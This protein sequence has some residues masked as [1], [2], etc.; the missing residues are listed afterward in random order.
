MKG[1]DEQRWPHEPE[2]A[3]EWPAMGTERWPDEPPVMAADATVPVGIDPETGRRFVAAAVYANIAL[4]SLA[5]GG[6]LAGV[7]GEVGWGATAVGVGLL[8]LLQ[9]IRIVRSQTQE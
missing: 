7:R 4:A 5:I 9:L 1:D 3:T 2:I 6:L 8:A